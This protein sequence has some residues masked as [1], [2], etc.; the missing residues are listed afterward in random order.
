MSMKKALIGVCA[1]AILLVP[2]VAWSVGNY[3]DNGDGTV[4]DNDTGLMWMKDGAPIIMLWQPALA[5]CEGLDL[6]GHSDWYL[7]NVKELQTLVDHS[8]TSPAIDTDYFVS[9]GSAYWSSSTS[10]QDP[11]TAWYVNFYH[12]SVNVNVNGKTGGTGLK[13]RCVR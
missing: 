12:G 5:Y 9:S 1:V 13:V 4:T 2:L 6:A 7:P 8:R 10:A 3:T 11:S